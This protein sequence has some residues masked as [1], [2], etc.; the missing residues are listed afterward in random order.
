[1]TGSGLIASIVQQQ[2]AN[3]RHYDDYILARAR[4]Y[5]DTKIDWVKQGEGRLKKQTIDKGLLRETES[6]QRQIS[7]LLKCDVSKEN[8]EFGGTT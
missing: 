3:I 6:V 4:A 1:V 2:G 5:R 7:A 8:Y